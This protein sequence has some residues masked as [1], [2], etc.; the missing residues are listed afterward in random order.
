VDQNLMQRRRQS[1]PQPAEPDDGSGRPAPAPRPVDFY[2][3]R[4]G[5]TQVIA[6]DESSAVGYA[7]REAVHF[8]SVAGISDATCAKIAIAVTEASSNILKHAGVGWL[9]LQ[10]PPSPTRV[11]EALALDKGGGIR[12]LGAALRGGFSTKGSAG[13]GLSAIARLAA[14]FDI[15][16]PAGGGTAVL[17]RF[18]DGAYRVP[19]FGALNVAKRGEPVCGDAWGMR[20]APSSLAVVVADGSGHGAEAARSAQIAVETSLATT[21]TPYDALDRAHRALQDEIRGAAVSILDLQYRSRRARF[22]GLGNVEVFVTDGESRRSVF[23]RGGIVGKSR[24]QPRESHPDLPIGS[25][26][27]AH[28]DGLRNRWTLADYP[29]LLRRDPLLAASVLW[30]DWHRDNDD[31][32]VVVVRPDPRPD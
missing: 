25:F 14:G 22:A 24:W 23:A 30:R 27:I 8:A 10:R 3:S 9:V 26:L 31:S 5:R 12:H 4:R 20:F 1:D 13:H 7:R 16:A 15:H 2:L 19:P 29:G 32:T 28:T 18:H 11:F 17:M 21:A 6:I